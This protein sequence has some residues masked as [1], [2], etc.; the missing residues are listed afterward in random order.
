[1]GV[2]PDGVIN[3]NKYRTEEEFENDIVFLKK[4]YHFVHLQDVVDHKLSGKALNANSVLLTF[5]DGL[6]VVYDKIRP[7]LLK[8][9]I[10]AV[11]FINP[12]FIDNKDLHFQRKKNLIARSVTSEQIKKQ[13]I[14]WKS[15]FKHYFI[16]DEDFFRAIDRIN[17]KK[18]MVLN[19]LLILFQINT[20]TYLSS[21]N[22]YLKSDQVNTM[23]SEG[24]Y[25]GGHSMDHPKYDELCLTD[26]VNQTLNSVKW[27]KEKFK[28]N[29]SVF[30][31]PLRDN[32]ISIELF[33]KINSR[34]DVTFGVAGMGD[35]IIPTHIQRID[36][37][38]TGVSIKR[39]L[40]FEY[41]KFIL[42]KMLGK[43]YYKRPK[44]F[45]K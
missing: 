16:S 21:H 37:E 4:Q 31:F 12:N 22:I 44:Y 9:G 26:Q 15:I 6:R 42:R 38:S 13:E 17:Y 3:K 10:S 2:D 25:F 41:L 23:I 28:L 11:F 18:S 7:I 36:V 8:H 1:M 24:F 20:N 35:D 33:D 30:A 39:V 34:C 43:T 32:N 14:S 27:V 40:K 45:K 5:D 29:Y 19:E